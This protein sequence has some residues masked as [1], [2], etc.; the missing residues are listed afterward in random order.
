[1]KKLIPLLAFLVFA[2]TTNDYKIQATDITPSGGW[3]LDSSGTKNIEVMDTVYTVQPSGVEKVAMVKHDGTV[4]LFG[5]GLLIFAAVLA[6]FIAVTI[7]GTAPESAV[8][9]LIIG[10][11][12]GLGIAYGSVDWVHTL[13]E[14]IPKPLY[15]SLMQK[16]GNLHAFWNNV[17]Y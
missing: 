10:M 3:V 15:D 7:K 14:P 2:C 13:Q 5:L 6:W 17:K 8:V 1:M 16:D 11:V 4:W 12:I 9:V